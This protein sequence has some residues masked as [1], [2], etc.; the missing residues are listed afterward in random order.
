[1][2]VFWSP[3]ARWNLRFMN[4][5]DFKAESISEHGLDRWVYKASVCRGYTF[6]APVQLTLG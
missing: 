5:C 2:D 1:M 6:I 3:S 4:Q